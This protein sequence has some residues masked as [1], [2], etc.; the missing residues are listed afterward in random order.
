[1]K[2]LEL[3]FESRLGNS[4]ILLKKAL[5][6]PEVTGGIDAEC[7]I[8]A[9]QGELRA[10][11]PELRVEW[12]EEDIRKIKWEPLCMGEHFLHIKER[13]ELFYTK[14]DQIKQKLEKYKAYKPYSKPV[15]A[16]GGQA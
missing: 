12:R 10:D 5:M 1:M 15:R 9:I 6:V 4:E 13:H 2:L 14:N 3:G 16:A 11:G 8:C 7:P